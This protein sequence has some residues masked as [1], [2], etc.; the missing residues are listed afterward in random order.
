VFFQRRDSTVKPLYSNRFI[1]TICRKMRHGICQVSQ[2]KENPES[3]EE[4]WSSI[5]DLLL[6]ACSGNPSKFTETQGREKSMRDDY[7]CETSLV[8]SAASERDQDSGFEDPNIA[9][10]SAITEMQFRSVMSQYEMAILRRLFPK[11]AETLAGVLRNRPQ[12]FD[13]EL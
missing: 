9:S 1:L 6:K 4:L 8:K 5:R 10:E 2:L 13:D 12:Q 11:C 3:G 7:S